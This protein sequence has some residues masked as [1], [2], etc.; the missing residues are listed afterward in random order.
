MA[1]EPTYRELFQAI[2]HY[3]PFDRMPVIHWDTWP[4]THKEWLEQGLPADV[5]EHEYLN[6]TPN[7]CGI[8]ITLDLCPAFEEETIEETDDHRIFRQKDGVIAQHWKN[9]SCI[10]HYI[11]FMMKDRSGWDEYKKRLQPCPER[12]PADFDERLKRLEKGGLP[13]AL[14]TFSM[15]G[16][17]RDWMGVENL[18]YTCYDDRELLAEIADIMAD[19]VCWAIDQVAGKVKIDM[20]TGWEDI[21]FKTGPLVSPH[22]FKECCVPAYRKVA[23]K[24]AENGCD[25]FLVDSDGDIR[26]LAPLWLEGG[27]NILF[28]I[29][30]GTW[31]ADPMDYRRKYGRQCR[32]LGGI[33]KNE[34]TKGRAAIDAEIERRLPLMRDGGYIPMPEHII[35]PGTPLDDYKYYLDRIRALRF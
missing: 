6:A 9:K 3:E 18:G 20:L 30:I 29:E 35:I 21:C 11:E 16:F 27:V 34:L 5:S 25:L 22:V 19:L 12:M 2:M 8:P 15:I 32:I 31:K 24:A 14:G 1:Q 26:A 28:P 4:E 23:D 13:I 17:T 33:D 7:C 10:P